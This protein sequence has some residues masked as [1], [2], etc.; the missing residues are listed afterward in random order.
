MKAF[1][2]ICAVIAVVIIGMAV[3]ATGKAEQPEEKSS[4][5]RVRIG[6]FDSRAVALVYYNSESFRRYIRGLKAETKKAEAAGD[7]E[8]VEELRIEGESSQEMAH[9][10]GFSTWPVDNIL[11]KIKGKI[12]E[13]AEQAD[14][15]VIVSKWDIVYQ[16]P[17]VEFIDITDLIVKPF[18]PDEQTL[19]VLEE[20]KKQDPIPLQE[21]KECTH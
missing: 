19:G 7:R 13:I 16:R 10:Q 3:C 9:K 20:L 12:P 17:E 1:R 11:E 21:L 6:T 8:R 4:Q 14:V 5:S 15:D 2:M 18:N